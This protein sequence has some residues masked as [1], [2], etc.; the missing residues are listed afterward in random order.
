MRNH[1]RPELRYAL[2]GADLGGF[3]QRFLD[4]ANDAAG[5]RER[6]LAAGDDAK[7]A[8]GIRSE[9]EALGDL[10]KLLGITDDEVVRDLAVYRQAVIAVA[11][12]LPDLDP[13]VTERLAR[14]LDAEQDQDLSELADVFRTNLAER[15]L[16][17]ATTHRKEIQ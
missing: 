10:V 9:R 8:A 15:Q 14:R 2:P 5:I 4:L 11:Q 7:A 3:A 1:V 12:L 13:D 6:G 16:A 17:L